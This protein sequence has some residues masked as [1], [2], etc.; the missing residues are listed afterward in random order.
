MSGI[1]GGSVDTDTLRRMTEQV[2]SG[3]E[4]TEQYEQGGMGVGISWYPTDPAAATTWEDGSRAGVVYGA[5][6][7]KSEINCSTE[8][9][10]C[11]LFDRPERTAAS[12]E[13]DF[14]IACVDRTDDRQI[15]V[16]NKLGARPCYYT[17]EGSFVYS[18]SLD[19]LLP[20]LPNPQYN[21][22]A[23]SDMLLM[24]H[25][26]GDK[27]LLSGVRTLRPATV[28]EVVNGTI[29]AS[30][31]WEP[32]YDQM[33]PG[34]GYLRELVNRYRT[35]VRRTQSTLP[36]E[37]GIWLSGGLDSRTT[38]GAFAQESLSPLRAYT[39]DA[40]PPTNDNPKI[41]AQVARALE[42]GF[43]YVPLTEKLFDQ[44]F[45]EVVD[46]TDGM[47]RWNTALNLAAT[48][49][50]RNPPPVMM[51]GIQGALLGDHLLRPHLSGVSSAVE[52]QYRSEA[53]QDLES[54]QSLLS[55]DVNPLASFKKEA[56]RSTK[57][58]RR[59][60][61]LDIHFQNYYTRNTLAS[62][63][64]MRGRLSTRVPHADGELLEW[65]SRLP[66]K[67]RKG[68]FPYTNGKVPYETTLAKLELIRRIDPTLAG[69][70]YERTKVKPSWPYRLHIAGFVF[71]VLEGRL[72]NTATYGGGQL[73]DF[74]IR[75][76][77]TNLH[78][79]I[80]DL[81]ESARDREIFNGDA[82]Q[83]VYADHLAGANNGGMLAQITTLEHWLQTRLD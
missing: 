5:I 72:H 23:I 37:A 7:N 79:R 73:A 32:S 6:T 30:R 36:N 20:N 10:F 28:M 45:E 57:S 68:A 69:I 43:E 19:A 3:P 75:D 53:A 78:T 12:L 39:Y 59:E 51:E 27:T 70:T 66:F 35:A 64:V 56:E 8:E 16:H 58:N 65:C 44:H 4:E 26:W 74:W 40:N 54:V 60:R 34:D 61:I 14:L 13:G 76:E 22:Q 17:T 15:L 1:A 77:T 83:E 18:T 2:S 49:G 41:A 48:Y 38:A 9:I 52:S 50:Q 31:Y 82:I 25:M 67:Y 80:A 62:N 42:I 71:N 33:A 21:K 47:V 11:R 81:V 46:T 55:Y 29:S 24:G 63:A